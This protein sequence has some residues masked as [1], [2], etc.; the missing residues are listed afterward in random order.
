MAGERDGGLGES[1]C[2]GLLSTQEDYDAAAGRL[3]QGGGVLK[4]LLKRRALSKVENV[5]SAR[6]SSG[7]FRSQKPR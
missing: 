4:L 3:A 6:G 7:L 5:L 1:A 2:L